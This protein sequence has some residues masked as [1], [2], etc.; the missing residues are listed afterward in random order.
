VL[1][2]SQQFAHFLYLTFPARG[3]LGVFPPHRSGSVRSAKLTGDKNM[4]AVWR[5]IAGQDARLPF[6]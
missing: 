2:L 6:L 3:I 5:D 4:L 1:P